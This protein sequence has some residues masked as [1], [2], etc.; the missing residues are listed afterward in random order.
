M[1]LFVTTLLNGEPLYVVA[2]NLTLATAAAKRAQS[3][4]DAVKVERRPE[5]VWV[6]TE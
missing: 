2:P 1:E 3:G 6:V 5:R 4:L